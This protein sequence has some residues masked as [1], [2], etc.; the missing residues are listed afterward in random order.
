[1]KLSPEEAARLYRDGKS[2]CLIAAD[3]KLTRNGVETR[4]RAAGV[5]GGLVWCPIHRIHEE[6]HWSSAEPSVVTAARREHQKWTQ[7]TLEAS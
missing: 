4:I 2:S 1:M 3:Y 5:T 6:L 7:P